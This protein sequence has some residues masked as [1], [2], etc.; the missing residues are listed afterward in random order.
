VVYFEG[1]ADVKY[2]RDNIYIGAYGSR[3]TK[4][5]LA[6]LST[7]FDMNIIPFRLTDPRLYHLDCCVAPVADDKVI[8]CAELAA[9]STLREIEKYASIIAV[10]TDEALHGITS[11]LMIGN[12]MLYDSHID[13]LPKTDSQYPAEVALVARIESI[14][15]E[16]N[17]EPVRMNLSE[18]YKSGAD[19]A[20]MVM[21]LNYANRLRS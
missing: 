4:T 12:R 3:T 1:E 2:L 21:Q 10:S 19:L 20:C 6:W 13:A 9:K 15:R 5:A 11:L 7:Q 8:V 14:C 16:L 18:F 17:I